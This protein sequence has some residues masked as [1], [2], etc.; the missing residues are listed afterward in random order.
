MTAQ[1]PASSA[2]SSPAEMDVRPR[3]LLEGPL[4][5]TLLK[6][7]A[8]NALVMITQISVGL[9]ELYFVAKLGVDALAGVSQV[10]PLLAL[11]GAISQGS[12]GGGPVGYGGRS[13]LLRAT[14]S[15]RNTGRQRAQDCRAG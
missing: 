7:A 13:Q 1:V 12:I 11:V 14:I 10:F 9:A 6:L 8:P 5:R 15:P 3:K 2:P 4:P